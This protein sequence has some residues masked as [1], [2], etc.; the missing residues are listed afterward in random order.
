VFCAG[1][2]LRLD[3]FRGLQGFDW[4]GFS[5]MN[6]LRQDKGQRACVTAFCQAVKGQAPAPVPIAEILEVGRACILVS[7]RT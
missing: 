6:L 5:K 7:E 3:N 4:P 2:I 1:G